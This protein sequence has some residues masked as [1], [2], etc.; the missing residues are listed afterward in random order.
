VQSTR[1]LM[2][3]PAHL[4]ADRIDRKPITATLSQLRLVTTRSSKLI[5]FESHQKTLLLLDSLIAKRGV[6]R[7]LCIETSKWVIPGPGPT[8][9]SQSFPGLGPDASM[10]ARRPQ[11]SGRGGLAWLTLWCARSHEL[12]AEGGASS[13]APKSWLPRPTPSAIQAADRPQAR[14]P[15]IRRRGGRR[16]ACPGSGNARRDRGDRDLSRRA[17]GRSLGGDAIRDQPKAGMTPESSKK[18]LAAV[19]TAAKIENCGG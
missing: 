18:L 19:L 4:T 9:I 6:R 10:R 15:R 3:I 7:E 12:Q 13:S 5:T 2:H 8:Q 11:F 16:S 14:H 1:Q 17:G